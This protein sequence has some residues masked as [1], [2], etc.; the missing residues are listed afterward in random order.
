MNELE[1]KIASRILELGLQEE[2]SNGNFNILHN[3]FGTLKND[4]NTKIISEFNL[5]NE[6]SLPINNSILANVYSVLVSDGLI[7]G[8]D[9][10]VLTDIS[11]DIIKLH[12]SYFNY[13]LKKKPNHALTPIEK[14]DNTLAALNNDN[15]KKES[16]N[17][18]QSLI[19]FETTNKELELILNK[20]Y[21]DGYIESKNI[22]KEGNPK[23]MKYNITYD[24]L[25]FSQYEGGYKEKINK[26]KVAKIYPLV[27]QT[28]AGIGA[29]GILILETIKIFAKFL[30]TF[31]H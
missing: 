23:I 10:V 30:D 25:M 15:Q 4:I 3:S 16:F 28:M 1:I 31:L 5:E 2:I 13:K 14:L 24:G 17:K 9:S 12:G 11:R 27:V 26:D 20:L 7:N 21:K 22:A 18:V 19:V 8:Y 6:S 29:I